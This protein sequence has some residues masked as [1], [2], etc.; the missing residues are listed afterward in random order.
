MHETL[1]RALYF[2]QLQG[3]FE[4]MVINTGWSYSRDNSKID[5]SVY[6]KFG[7]QSASLK[8]IYISY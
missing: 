8:I 4:T 2:F 1:Y 3:I 7:E 5:I 6:G